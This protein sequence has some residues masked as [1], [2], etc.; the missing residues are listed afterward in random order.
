M[1]SILTMK[2]LLTAVLL[3]LSPI[4]ANAITWQQFWEP[5]VHE[6]SDHRHERNRDNYREHF[7]HRYCIKRIRREEYVPGNRWRPGY[8]RTW[9]EEV[10]CGR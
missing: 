1:E 4:P 10:P 3:A 5:F 2:L 8:V 6:D 9:Y 7:Y